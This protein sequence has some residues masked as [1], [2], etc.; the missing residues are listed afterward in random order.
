MDSLCP[1]CDAA[2]ERLEHF[3]F[4]C[5]HARLCWFACPLGLRAPLPGNLKVREWLFAN[6]DIMDD[7]SFQIIAMMLWAIS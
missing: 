6:L 5:S 1:C 4:E 3:F 7:D 2:I